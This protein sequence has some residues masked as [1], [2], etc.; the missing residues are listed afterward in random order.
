MAQTAIGRAA[1]VLSTD[2]T[3]AKAGLGQLRGDLTRWAGDTAKQVQSRFSFGR[4]GLLGGAFGA[5][6]VI[7]S[8]IVRGVQ[9]ALSVFGDL[10][11]K[12]DDAAKA[13][14]RFGTSTETWQ[15]IAHAADL[16][17]VS[18]EKLR[19]GMIR[20]RQNVE[21]P[22][23]EA[24]FN[25]ADRYA[26]LDSPMERAQL[27]AENFGRSGVELSA[28]FEGG[29]ESLR[30]MVGEM[31]KYGAALQD[32]DA[33]KI[34][35]ANDAIT[36]A[37][38]AVQGIAQR[39]L[40]AY[41]PAL[42]FWA[43]R[44]ASLFTGVQPL[45]SWLGRAIEAFW[46]IGS[47]VFT[48]VR[49]LVL[50]IVDEVG[51]WIEATFGLT[52][53]LPSIRDVFFAVFRGIGTAGAFMW[54]TLKAGAGAVAVAFGFVIEQGGTMLSLF[55][56]VT[57]LAKSLP[58]KFRPEGFD[59]FASAVAAADDQVKGWGARAQEWGRDA[60]AG[61]GNS[62]RQFNDWLDRLQNKQRENA[63]KAARDVAEQQERAT[64]ELKS[65]NAAL[66]RGSS[67]EVSARLRH[68]F[69]GK[70]QDQMLNEQKKGNA[71]LG[72][73]NRNV[74]RLIEKKVEQLLPL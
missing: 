15:G 49:D 1:L 24:L 48:E 46:E 16:S 34:E 26:S 20:F 10:R 4:A 9:R 63:V 74:E 25:L 23:D 67:A 45:V 30:G 62:A 65:D 61:W 37:K 71:E 41:A 36:R 22:L 38:L 57:D 21:G 53:E 52:A 29:G 68:E 28:M 6:A 72:K 14:R 33:T 47:A 7:G 58:E 50:A 70:V 12:L 40:I 42:Q 60:I 55:R 66:L 17:G 27:L 69:G 64:A 43:D 32:A 5:G 13:A 56:Q 3:K 8:T 18:T 54:D 44:L 31:T 39:L 73:L 59:A 11:T 35:A 19:A 51:N 2:S